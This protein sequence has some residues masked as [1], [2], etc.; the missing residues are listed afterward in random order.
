MGGGGEQRGR[1]ELSSVPWRAEALAAVAHAHV[2]AVFGAERIEQPHLA[3]VSLVPAVAA[4][5]I[6]GVVAEGRWMARC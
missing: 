6:K 1:V 4:V 2:G 5:M 3:R